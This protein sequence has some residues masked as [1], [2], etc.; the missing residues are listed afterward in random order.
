MGRHKVEQDKSARNG[1]RGRAV[2]RGRE[3]GNERGHVG[4]GGSGKRGIEPSLF[5]CFGRLVRCVA[6][7]ILALFSILLLRS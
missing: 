4:E 3:G 1:Y 5:A 6:V 2:R 7:A